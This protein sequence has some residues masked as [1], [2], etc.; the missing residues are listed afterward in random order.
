LTQLADSPL[1]TLAERVA[2]TDPSPGAG[3][4]LAWTCALAGSLVEMVSAVMLAKEPDGDAGA[5]GRRDRAGELRAQAL[6]LADTDAA[7]YTEVLAV[8]RR[9]QEPGHGPRLR[10]ALSAAADPPLAIA[11]IAAELT[12]LA[13]AAAATAR[14]GVRGEAVTAAVLAEAVVRAGVP[15]IEMNLASAPE[16]PRRA[17]AQELAAGAA[18]D[19]ARA[20]GG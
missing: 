2:S 10:A 20:V 1:A 18:A 12:R 14:G 8:L 7:A 11:E 16:D 13:A 19:L 4:T 17:R 15:V 3:P 5:A 9:R 6:A